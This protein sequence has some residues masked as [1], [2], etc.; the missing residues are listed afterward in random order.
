MKKF[1]N[2]KTGKIQNAY[3]IRTEGNKTYVKFSAQGTEYAYNS[4]NITEISEDVTEIKTNDTF[5]LILYSYTKECWKCHKEISVYTYIVFSD[6][7][8]ESASFPWDKKRALQHQDIFS[9]LQ[10]PSIEYYGVSIVGMVPQFDTILLQKYPNIFSMQYSNTT[11]SYYC[12]NTCTYCKS[13]QGQYPIFRDINIAIKSMHVLNIY[14][15]LNLNL[16][17]FH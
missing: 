15:I 2:K 3:S 14:D 9:H 7:T 1:I 6:G 11:H 5:P 8:F 16:S 13:L 4:E 12:A 10:D 17:Q